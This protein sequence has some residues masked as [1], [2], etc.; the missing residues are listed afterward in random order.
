MLAA[1]VVASPARAEPP[2]SVDARA[3]DVAG[4]KTGMDYNEALQAAAKHFNVPTGQIKPD[5]FPGQNI[6]TGTKLPTY[7]AYE[8]DGAK[9]T[10]HFE[11]RVPPDP[12]RPLVAWLIDYEVPWSKDNA[13]A[14]AKAAVAKYGKPSN[15]P[16]TLPMQWCAQPS[17]NPGIGCANAQ[18]ALELSQVHMKLTDQAWQQARIAFVSKRTAVKPAF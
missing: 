17:A 4:V 11:G 3:L 15:A 7:F 9:L 18:A 6:V 14:M 5:P 8:K 13:D 2:R 12:T 16:N 1:C 10:V